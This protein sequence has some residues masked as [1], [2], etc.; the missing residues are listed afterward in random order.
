MFFW[1]AVHG[2]LK[3]QI[4]L[5]NDRSE[6]ATPSTTAQHSRCEFSTETHWFSHFIFKFHGL[7][8]ASNIQ[9]TLHALGEKSLH[10]HFICGKQEHSWGWVPSQAQHHT[11]H[12]TAAQWV[13]LVTFPYCFCHISGEKL[14][15]PGTQEFL[16]QGCSSQL[17]W[18]AGEWN[19]QAQLLLITSGLQTCPGSQSCLDTRLMIKH[20]TLG[21]F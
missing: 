7:W 16:S 12:K 1:I 17:C 4:T 2:Q 21:T 10:L 19:T 18:A 8:W 11:S 15:F 3:T 14:L 20:L 9:T 5:R 6:Q 13:C